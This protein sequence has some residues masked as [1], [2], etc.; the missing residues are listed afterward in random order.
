MATDAGGG[1]MDAL[2]AR[3]AVLQ[4]SSSSVKSRGVVLSLRD[5][6]VT[7]F[8]PRLTAAW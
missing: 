3:D 7:S 5:M 6:L 8:D 4:P 1:V 2:A